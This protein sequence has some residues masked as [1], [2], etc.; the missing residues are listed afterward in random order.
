MQVVQ[1]YPDNM[2]C[3]VDLA[4]TDPAAA[5][6]FYSGLF[7]WEYYDVPTPMGSHYSMCQIN[8]YNV[9]GLSNLPAEMMEQGIPPIWSSYIKHDDVDAVAEK[10]VAAGGTV[11]MPTMDVMESGRMTII[12]D[13]TG[14]MVGLWQ[15][16][17]HIG[18]QLVNMPNALVWN[19]LQTKDVD[20]ARSFYGTVFGWGH[21]QDPNGY[22]MFKLGERMQAGMLKLDDSWG[23]IPP[24]WGVYFMSEDIEA[25]TA[26]AK[27]LGGQIHVPP[28]DTGTVGRFAVIGD[29]QG[30]V[31][32]S[33]QFDGPVDAPPG[34]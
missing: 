28:T 14:A 33:M 10:A 6:E 29:P 3:W 22:Q 25:T 23:E 16:K 4:T 30:G 20:T 31:F 19:E 24:H 5:K 13:P 11:A 32:T 26:R 9:A 18:A 21:D 34:Y 17:E 8:G 12:Q 1:R 2:F 27:E 15:P 7:G